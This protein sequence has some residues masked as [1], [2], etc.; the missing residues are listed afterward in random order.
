MSIFSE[1]IKRLGNRFG[2]RNVSD[3]KDITGKETYYDYAVLL[4]SWAA[5]DGDAREYYYDVDS[6]ATSDDDYVV[7][8]NSIDNDTLPGRWLKV[9]KRGTIMYNDEH[10]IASVADTQFVVTHDLDTRE[11]GVQVWILNQTNGDFTS[12]DILLTPG[13]ANYVGN[14]NIGI[15]SAS[16][17]RIVIETPIVAS[18]RTVIFAS[19]ALMTPP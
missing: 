3:L 17:V 2:V 8:P 11:V 6:H 14:L 1:R 9:R 13:V 16:T 4:G 10:Y 19:S 15:E 5:N 12:A 7:R 18:Y